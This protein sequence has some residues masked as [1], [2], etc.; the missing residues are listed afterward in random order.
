MTWDGEQLEGKLPGRQGRLIFAYLL[1]NRSRPVR[2]DELVEALWADEG[3]PTG[4]ESLLA[5]PLSRL[6]KALGQNRLEGRTELTL[7]LGDQAQVDCE[8][9]QEKLAAAQDAGADVGPE[10]LG[11]AWQDAL[12][13]ASILEG[14]LLPG[15]DARWIDEHRAYFDELRLKSLEAVARIGARL[16]PAEQSKAERA[17]RSAVEASPF[18]ESA[19]AALIE[20]LEAQGNVAEAMRSYEELRVLLRDELGSF[21]SPALSAI[22]DRLLRAHEGSGRAGKQAGTPAAGKRSRPRPTAR[23]IGREIDPRIEDRRLVGRDRILGSLRE[24]LELATAGELRI[25]LL[26]GEGGVG[27]T[28]LAA[29]LA[30]SRDDVVTLYGRAE[31]DEVRPFSIWSG[32]L[33]SAVRQAV[34]IDPGKIVGG[35]GP[36]LARLLPELGRRMDLPAPG[37]TS[38]LESERQALFGAVMRMIGRFSSRQPML[39][40]LDDL[41]WADRSTLRLLASLAGDN[42]PLGILA[43]G[44]YRDTE[45]PRDSHL[46]ETLS[47]LQ[48]RLP[49]TRIP[50]DALDEKDVGRLIAGRLDESLAPVIRDQTGG[51]PFF[52]EQLVRNLE[53]S[54]AAGPGEVPP[55]IREV[56]TQRVSRL[57]DGSP[58]VLARAAL[59]GRDFSLEIIARTTSEEEDRLIELLDASVSAGL[60]DESPAVPGRYSFVH[61]L[62]RSTLGESL[63]LTRRATVHRQI[64]EAI[65]QRSQTAGQRSRNLPILAWHFS[66]A[67]PSEADRAVH[68]ATLAARQAEE[69]LAYDEAVGFYE[70]AIATCRADEPVDHGLLAELLLS[71][72]GAEWRMGRLPQ[73][74]LTF[75]TAAE[76]AR[77]SGRSELFARAA[78]G[79]SWSSWETFENVRDTPIS[80]LTE[81]LELLPDEVS[82]LQA[83]TLANLAH[84]KFFS[85]DPDDDADA[86]SARA[87]AMADELDDATYF[88]VTVSLQFFL[89]QSKSAGYRLDAADRAVRIAEES[90]DREDLAEAL[91]LRAVMLTCAGKGPES[92]ADIRRLTELSETLPQVRNTSNSLQ[93]A[94]YFLE[95]RWEEGERLTR[96]ALAEDIPSSARVA[97][98]DAMHYMDFAQRGRLGE[99]VDFLE[100]EAKVAASWETWPAWEVGLALGYW[101][102]GDRERAEAQIGTV[103]LRSVVSI[104]RMD[105]LKPVFCGVGVLLASAMENRALAEVITGLLDGKDDAWTIFGPGAPTFGPNSLLRGEMLLLLDRDEEAAAA[106]EGA[107]LTCESMSARPFLARAELALAEAQERLGDPDGEDRRVELRR[108]GLETARE[109]DLKPLLDRHG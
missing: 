24:E 11:A 36:T 60:L 29:E 81:A 93:A 21:P 43:L 28:R 38:D 7:N 47:Q 22:H 78:N 66:Q 88:R 92:S 20:V 42:P 104:T 62:V 39:I 49:T 16:G 98:T 68:Y 69:R 9:A 65:E 77:E 95:G 79:S 71:K 89:L 64:G 15:L 33:R 19:R 85:G 102:A 97:M 80:L 50:V 109:L 99:V 14:G 58:E 1:L 10:V 94:R 18:R 70:G 26:A 91:A 74:G 40:V 106:L 83:E 6:R 3:L 63:S 57:P 55:E 84:L 34:D 82:P 17:A 45:L 73:S 107:I 54:G 61:A 37:P 108:S 67:G 72:A 25:A 56:I 35:D 12:E 105:L 8:V 53:E 41:H 2:R 76:A 86:M 23:S 90:E 101:Q 51:N 27:K 75:V 87:I 5:P 31:P 30:A 100:L 32:L 96:K 4:G 44:I 46:P 52:I 59:A 103:D 48:R 13:A